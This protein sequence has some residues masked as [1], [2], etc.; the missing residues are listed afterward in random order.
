MWQRAVRL[1]GDEVTNRMRLFGR[2]NG[3]EVTNR[4][5]MDGVAQW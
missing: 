5:V 4:V 3:D 2:P 1:N